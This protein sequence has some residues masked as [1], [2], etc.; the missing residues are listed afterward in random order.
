[1]LA[2]IKNSKTFV[3]NADIDECALGIDDCAENANCTNTPGSFSCMCDEGY[4]GDGITCVGKHIL[5]IIP[6]LE[7]VVFLYVSLHTCYIEK[8]K[9]WLQ[10]SFSWLTKQIC[11]IF[12]G[13]CAMAFPHSLCH[14][15]S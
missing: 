10:M 3:F 5:F 6:E 4:V 2:I 12:H 11:S 7:A 15:A 9:K 8:V 14:L 1:M 13:T